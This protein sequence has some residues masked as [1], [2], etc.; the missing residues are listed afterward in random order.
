MSILKYIFC[1]TL[2]ASNLF[3]GV[4]FSDENS[5]QDNINFLTENKMLSR[6]SDFIDTES[7]Y[8]DLDYVVNY[9]PGDEKRMLLL[10]AQSGVLDETVRKVHELAKSIDRKDL[11]MAI[12]RSPT[13]FMMMLEILYP[14]QYQAIVAFSGTP[15][16]INIRKLTD[17]NNDNRRNIVTTENLTV[18]KNYLSK[19]LTNLEGKLFIIDHIGTGTSLNSFLR[20]LRKLYPDILERTNLVALNIISDKKITMQ[21]VINKKKYSIF[22]Y[23]PNSKRLSLSGISSIGTRP[24]VIDTIALNMNPR[25]V[26]MYDNAI[27]KYFLSPFGPFPA[28]NWTS[29][30]INN[31]L[32]SI[33]NDFIKRHSFAKKII[34][35]IYNKSIETNSTLKQ[36]GKTFEKIDK[37]FILHDE[38]L[39]LWWR[40][41]KNM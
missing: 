35:A 19:Y 22:Q 37:G 6:D 32:I 38:D 17:A 28:C 18:Y 1:I 23:G 13:I 11:V 12:G 9:E 10:A 39:L 8:T 41:G 4:I 30:Y 7:N 25:T 2:F 40:C 36:V 14:D 3:C 33:N 21:E 15:D 16:T 31:K 29:D 24:L 27:I 26:L 20:I 34:L 5:P